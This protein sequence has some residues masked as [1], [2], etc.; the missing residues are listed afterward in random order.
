MITLLGMTSTGNLILVDSNIVIYSLDDGS[1]K[2]KVAKNFLEEKS[3]GLVLSHQTLLETYRVITH[4]A[5]PRP[6]TAKQAFISLQ[7]I[8]EQRIIISP[9]ENTFEI[10]QELILK[11]GLLGNKIF[12][13]YLVA[14]AVSWGISTIATDN[15]KDFRIFNEVKVINPFRQK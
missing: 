14:T 8:S 1:P 2:S 12:D 9:R 3:L 7:S 6:Y 5:Y 10:T 13:A 15:E 11:H 4:R